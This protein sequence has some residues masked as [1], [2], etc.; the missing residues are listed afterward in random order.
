MRRLTPN[1]SLTVEFLHVQDSS[2]R[3]DCDKL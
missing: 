2:T 1:C 3:I